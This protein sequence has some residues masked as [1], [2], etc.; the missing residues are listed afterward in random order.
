MKLL[1]TSVFG[2]FGVDDDYGRKD[3][4][5]ELFHNQVTREQ[6]LFS[7]RFHYCSFGLHFLAEN[8]R[9]PSTVLDFP[10]MERFVE[11][12]QK[13]Y[14]YVGISFIIPNL[15]KAQKMAELVRRHAPQSKIILG[16]HGTNAPGVEELVAHD[17]IC[18]GEG[19]RYLRELFHEEVD[20]PIKHPLLHGSFNKRIMGVPVPDESGLIISGVGCPNKCR[21]CA[22][23]HFFREYTPYL[24]TGREIYDLCCRY[25]EEMGI[26]DFGVM[27]ENFLKD[28]TRAL[29][30]LNLME[31]HQRFF[32]FAIF[33]SAETLGLLEN[34]DVLVRLGVNFIWMG[35]ESRKETYEKNKG[36]D[37]KALVADLRRRGICVMTSIILFAEHHDQETILDDMDFAVDLNSDYVQFMQ[38]GPIPGTALYETYRQEGKLLPDVPYE[39]Q[40]GQNQ[41]WFRHPSFTVEESRRFLLKA[42]RMDYQ[43]NGASFLRVIKTY[44]NGLRYT[45]G[46]VRQ[47][48]QNRRLQFD[49]I[50]RRARPFLLSAKWFSQNEK[51]TQL[52]AGIQRDYREL[53]GR[54]NLKGKLLSMVV[55]VFSLVERIRISLFSDRRHPPCLSSDYRP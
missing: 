23:S 20:R 37:F 24:K 48:I 40:H 29:E 19:V 42:F 18:R 4:K 21:F 38:L 32:T 46:S 26:T 43:T 50:T 53:L 30:L 17:F 6:G 25:E 33:S 51:T 8:I 47:D 16:G 27:D 39:E 5:M 45:S 13:G 31:T 10:S 49:K 35:V 15:K 14:D 2:P 41:I 22:T 55:V 3:N 12:I 9:M 28:K 11:E 44:L 54:N 36:V 34:L 7:F 1:L 52:L